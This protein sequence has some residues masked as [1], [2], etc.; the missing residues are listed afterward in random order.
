ML[1]EEWRPIKDYPNYEISNY[2]Q[3]RSWSRGRS[4]PLIVK[5]GHDK[6]GYLQYPMKTFEGKRKFRRVHQLV[7]E[8][9]VE[10]KPFQK[11]E[12]CH[13]DG[14]PQNNIVTNLRWDTRSNNHKDS[15]AHGTTKPRK[16]EKS[17]LAKLTQEQVDEIIKLALAKTYTQK[18]I[19]EMF[20][21]TQGHVS[22][23]LN[24]KRWKV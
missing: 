17:N 2:G 12:V 22:A 19:G 18:V 24:G 5:L 14:N 23:L 4:K 1:V 16:R 10:E 13:N 20:N 15:L 8:T 7:L 6:N 11:A 9:F 3:I 21:I